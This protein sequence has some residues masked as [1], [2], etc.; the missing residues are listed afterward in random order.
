M[1]IT[2]RPLTIEGN[3]AVLELAPQIIQ[4]ER[5]VLIKTYDHEL[6]SRQAS[7]H[8]VE[9]QQWFFADIGTL[10]G[11]HFQVEP[12]AQA[13]LIRVLRGAVLNVAVD[14]RMESATYGGHVV[15]ATSA[16]DRRQLFIPRGFAHGLCTLEPDT[17]ILFK[18][19]APSVNDNVRGIL[20]NDPDLGIEWPVDP[21]KV[22]VSERD[23]Q[24]PCLKD[25]DT[26]FRSG[27]LPPWMVC[28]DYATFAYLLAQ[29]K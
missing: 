7:F 28:D 2:M 25:T 29:K 24:L 10:R 27:F 4:D 13:K 18:A 5:G 16:Q 19:D 21:D 11:L 17:E 20:W 3:D 9:E 15:A 8:L 6:L 23:R 1:M 26:K 22:I 14:I 12:Y